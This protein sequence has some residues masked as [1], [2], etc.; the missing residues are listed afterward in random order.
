ME[1]KKLQ[2]GGGLVI[3]KYRN[4]IRHPKD[5]GGHKNLAEFRVL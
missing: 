1:I 5:E 3:E 4:S 2:Q